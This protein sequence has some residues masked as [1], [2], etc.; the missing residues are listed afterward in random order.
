MRRLRVALFSAGVL[1]AGALVVA[2]APSGYA[3]ATGLVKI[4]GLHAP[5]SVVRDDDGIAHIKAQNA[6]DLFFLQGWV[7]A[8]DRLFQMDARRRTGSG[9]LAELLGSSA[10]PSDVQLRT[11][12]LRRTVER[13]LSVLSSETQADLR[14]YADGVNAWIARN[15]LP[16]Q[17]ATVQVTKVAP[18]TVADSLLVNKLLTFSLS[19]DLDIDRTTAVQR[20][21][22]AGLDGHTAVFQDVFPFAPFNTASP[23]IDSTATPASPGTR[24]PASSGSIGVSDD[25]ERLAADYL[26]KAEQVPLIVEAMNRSAER[27]SNSWVIGGQ[28]TA[29]GKPIL[30][31][32]PHL[33]LEAPST[34]QPI[35]LQGGGFNAQGDSLPGTPYLILGQ[36]RDITYG[37]TQHFV[38]VTD[39]YTEKIQPDPASP[40]GLS[41]LYQGRLEPVVAIDEKYRVNPRTPGQ[42][43]VLN[44]VPAGGT[45]PAKTLI[46]PRRNNG[47]LVAVNLAAG[48]ALS[49]QYT[50]W[51]PTTE[52]ETFRRFGLARNVDDFRDA[53]QFFDIGGQH[54]TYA[55]TKGNIAYFTNAEVPV[56]EDLQA[57]MVKGNPPYLLRDGT[58]G[59]EWLPVTNRQ[60]NQSLPYEIVPFSELPK[61]VNPPAGFIVSANNDPTANSF[62]NNVLNQVRPGGGIAYLGFSHNGFRAGRIT[63]MV[64][65]AVA[66]GRITTADVVKMQADVTALDAQF[67]TPVITNALDRAKR[68]ST[69]ELAALV[70]DP[71][72]VEAV[73]RLAKWNFT[74]PT[75][76]PEGYDSSDV[77]GKLSKPSQQEI[78]NS[79]AATIYALWRS[80]FAVNVIDQHVP[81]TSPALPTANLEPVAR[82]RRSGSFW[83]TSTPA[84]AS[85]GPG[86]TSSPCRGLPTRPTGVTS[87]CSRASVTRSLWPPATTSRRRSATRPTRATTGGASCTGSRSPR[88]SA[89]RSRSR[90]R[91]TGSPRRCPA[92]PASRSTVAPTCPTRPAT[93]CG[94][95]RRKSSP[96]GRA[97]PPVRRPGDLGWL[98]VGELA[99]HRYQRG[100]RQQVRAEPAPRLAH[101]R[102]VSGPAFPAGSR[103]AHRL[104][105]DVRTGGQLAPWWTSGP[106]QSGGVQT[107]AWHHSTD[108]TGRSSRC[109]PFQRRL[110][111][112]PDA[113]VR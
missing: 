68:S 20:Y 83:S 14:A 91:A 39:T 34:L 56:R 47:P 81:Q 70:K 44:D 35:D 36:N 101:Q 82:S 77:D 66:K 51:S 71:R 40:S 89:R 95:T 96:L 28:H 45:I 16:S 62:D 48:T 55:D 102:H 42:Q 108:R 105:H 9:T 12:G 17:Y 7:H 53:M 80:R 41:T 23:V 85:V 75:G 57:G 19:F 100:P 32:D 92:C 30:A 13:S 104:D 79:A 25:A 78:D 31:S 50:G 33:T 61:V 5:A 86:S 8:D 106:R 21:S 59:N 22:A 98:A 84:R 94:P 107:A 3:D 24:N 15:K 113:P 10:L 4:P 90:R 58:G 11:F 112:R 110:P 109:V 18:W 103:R 88:C 74:Y 87:W 67:F 73:G 60:P 54:F 72:I 26:K 65:A 64:K 99:V 37:A 46:V 49:V 93:S 63:D 43:D 97:A 69:P 1:A 111:G 6:H 2:S 27:G 29:T 52:L 76:I 38:D